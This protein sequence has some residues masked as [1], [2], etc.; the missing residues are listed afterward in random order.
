MLMMYDHLVFLPCCLH[1]ISLM[2]KTLVKHVSVIEMV[3]NNC[4]IINFFTK[5]HTWFQ[6]SK[7]FMNERAHVK[8]SLN[9]CCKTQWYSLVEVC[10]SIHSYEEFFNIA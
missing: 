8:K 4:K 9:L 6:E 2:L 7:V 5:S 1:V 10:T 3:K